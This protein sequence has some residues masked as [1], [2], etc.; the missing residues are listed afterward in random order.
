MKRVER[1]H[2]DAPAR[3]AAQLGD[4]RPPVAPVVHRQH[5]ERGV[6]G[7]VGERQRARPRACTAGAAS[8]GRCAI[9]TAEG[10]TAV[11][12]AVARLVGAD[13]RADVDDAA[14]VAERV[15]DLRLDARIGAA[16]DGVGRPDR[17][18]GA[19]ARSW[20]SSRSIASGSVAAA[21]ADA[22]A[23]VAV[24]VHAP[25]Q[26][27]HALLGHEA[28]VE[29]VDALGAA[30][31]RE[32]DRAG[33]G[34]HP[35]EPV[36]VLGDQRVDER[37]VRGDDRAAALGER[38]R[39]PQGDRAEHLGGRRAAERRVVAHLRDGVEQ[40]AVARR[41]PADPQAGERVGLGEHADADGARREVGDRRQAV[42]RILLEAAVDL[43]ADQRRAVALGERGEPASSAAVGSMPV[44]LCGRLTTS[45]RVVGRRAAAMRSRSSRQPSSGR[46]STRSTS[47]PCAR[48]RS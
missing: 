46:S 25:G 16:R 14:G 13:A 4:A 15:C 33:R 29:S 3:D 42:G 12:V 8:A 31:A 32:A 11:D 34:P 6:E 9:I 10:S 18:V 30:V 17:V 27:Q 5:R 20:R 35:V 38:R 23:P 41:E 45:A 2:D 24:A 44:G 26:E 1:E 21:E 36:G 7:V 19:H 39:R 37:Q 28:L 22:E 48:A 47:A 43:V 40:L